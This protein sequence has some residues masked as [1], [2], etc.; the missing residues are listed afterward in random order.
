[1]DKK[2]LIRRI[3]LPLPGDIYR[4][5][6]EIYE[7]KEQKEQNERETLVSKFCNTCE[8]CHS[9]E[10]AKDIVSHYDNII[11]QIGINSKLNVECLSAISKMSEQY[12]VP[13][14]SEMRRIWIEA[15]DN[16]VYGNECQKGFDKTNDLFFSQTNGRFTDEYEFGKRQFIFLTDNDKEI[17][18]C[19]DKNKRIQWVFSLD[20]RPSDIKFYPAG[21]PLPYNLYVAHPV[22][23]GLYFPYEI[24]EDVIFDDKVEDYCYLLQCLGATRITARSI[25]GKKISTDWSGKTTFESEGGWGP[26]IG[27]GNA[28]IGINH[29]NH[30]ETNDSTEWCWQFSPTKK[31]FVPENLAWLEHEPEW[32]KIVMSRTNGNTTNWTKKISSLESSCLNVNI[33]SDLD[34]SFRFFLVKAQGKMES[35]VKVTRNSHEETIWEISADFK[36]WEEFE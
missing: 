35:D 27:T 22:K 6:K 14:I 9:A 17:A 34:S 8:K 25:K 33:Y 23:K 12:N 3:L 28:K 7:E 36:P 2:K 19:I 26:I 32:Q 10:E 5:G 31:P 29:N 13:K 16:I 18:G 30:H 24:A 11:S 21:H 1:M 15:M 4:T 20:K